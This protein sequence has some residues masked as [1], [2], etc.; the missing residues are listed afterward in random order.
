MI[1]LI[2][3]IFKSKR[4]YL[5]FLLMFALCFGIIIL[6]INTKQY[7][8][9]V[10]ES[11]VGNKIINRKLVIINNGNDIS[12]DI[13][14]VANI[15][16]CYPYI[17]INGLYNEMNFNIE[18]LSSAEYNLLDGNYIKQKN[19]ILVPKSFNL[20]INQVIG[21]IINDEKYD[22]KIVG[23]SSSESIIISKDFLTML[24]SNNYNESEYYYLISENY[25]FVE[26]TINSLSEKGYNVFLEN[27]DGLNEYIELQKFISLL[28]KFIY[29]LVLIN[30]IFIVYIIKNIFL[31]ELKNIAILKAIG[32]TN[33]NICLIALFKVLILLFISFIIPIL[34]FMGVIA[35]LN[36]LFNVEYI[37][38]SSKNQFLLSY[39]VVCLC[40]VLLLI[41]NYIPL[42]S[43]IKK[44]DVIK[45]INEE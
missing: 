42:F 32:Y 45:I 8:Q 19:E 26:S 38:F 27:T 29:F 43:K 14:N 11:G 41:L 13:K 1:T 24:S 30:M 40:S 16:D 2:T 17:Y 25:K 39:F 20:D 7:Y 28:V 23:Y 21:I 18:Y 34:I 36:K 5:P 10:L 37:L 22:L 31:A 12:N 44:I 33:I 15:I 35:I 6:L 3:N 4:I 9:Y